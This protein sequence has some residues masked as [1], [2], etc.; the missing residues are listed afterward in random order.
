VDVRG[1][2]RLGLAVGTLSLVA[3]LLRAHHTGDNIDAEI[4]L[5]MEALT[6][7]LFDFA[8]VWISY[9]ALEPWVRRYWPQTLVTWSRVLQGRWRDPMVGR[10]LLFAIL[11][12]LL[13][14][15]VGILA[16]AIEFRLGNGAPVGNFPLIILSGARAV[17]SGP[18]VALLQGI[19]YSLLL[20]LALFF[21]KVLL[22]KQWLAAVAFVALFAVFQSRSGSLRWYLVL[23]ASIAV[24]GA[25]V[26]IMLRLGVFASAVA[27]FIGNLL[28]LGFLTNHFTAWYGLSSWVAM[29]IVAFLAIWGFRLSLA[30]QPMFSGAAPPLAKA[31]SS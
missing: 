24:Y 6:G 2:T 19:L 11:L 13:M 1:A 20:F 16:D 28:S 8:V 3:W 27:I 17:A 15:A 25:F 5:F 31:A 12:T 26:L 4:Y 23:I 30:G 18:L 22:R 21:L 7:A 14:Q 10:D 29:A 9:L